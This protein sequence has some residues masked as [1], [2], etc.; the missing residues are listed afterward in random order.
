MNVNALKCYFIFILLCLIFSQFLILFIY[1]TPTFP[2][3]PLKK[4]RSCQAPSWKFGRCPNPTSRK[5]GPHYGA[6]RHWDTRLVSSGVSLT[7]W[8]EGASLSLVGHPND[9]ITI[10]IPYGVDVLLHWP[11]SHP[12]FSY[13]V[14]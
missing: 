5:G 13:W 7:S 8:G 9:D 12:I 4:S 10:K 2:A 6:L 11:A 14:S 3:M 1:V